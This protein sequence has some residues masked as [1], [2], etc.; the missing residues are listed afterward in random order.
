MF[1]LSSSHL[2]TSLLLINQIKLYERCISS[3]LDCL[4]SHVD[5]GR[6]AWGRM[7]Q[8]SENMSDDSLK[9]FWFGRKLPGRTLISA[10]QNEIRKRKGFVKL[11]AAAKLS[12]V[13]GVFFFCI[14][15][16]FI[17]P[18]DFTAVLPC[19]QHIS[20]HDRPLLSSLPLAQLAIFLLGWAGALRR[21]QGG[22]WIFTLHFFAG[23]E[24]FTHVLKMPLLV[25][26]LQSK[27]GNQQSSVFRLCCE[28]R[29][30]EIIIIYSLIGGKKK[31]NQSILKE[32]MRTLP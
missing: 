7:A 16:Q 4:I 23:W 26:H 3:C 9:L 14:M 22:D 27:S 13:S 6:C 15:H 17:H 29:A 25:F 32:K 12:E 2:V 1:D 28:T 21:C 11:L 8:K 30:W 31:Q 19:L 20:L 10:Y 24:H 5:G 18:K